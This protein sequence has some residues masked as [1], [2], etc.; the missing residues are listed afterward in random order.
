MNSMLISGLETLN[1]SYLEAS[2]SSSTLLQSK[3]SRIEVPFVSF[4]RLRLLDSEL[5][6]IT[7]VSA[8][9]YIMIWL[10]M[11]YI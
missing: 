1:N 9:I 3:I 7:V 10:I 6:V 4:L 11:V 5:V 2:F 8:L